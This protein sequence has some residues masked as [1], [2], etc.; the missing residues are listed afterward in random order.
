MG[1]S[2]LTRAEPIAGYTPIERVGAGGY[3]EV[4]KVDAP[5]GL[6]KAIK[7]VYG[8]MDDARAARE[9]KALNR[10]KQ[11]RHPF[12]LSLERIEV[13]DGQLLIVTELADMSLKDR[14]E[15]CRAEGLPGIPRDELL[16]YLR[17]AADAL[18]YMREKFSLQHLDVKPE[19]LLLVGGRVKVAD[20]GLVKDLHEVSMS[21]MGGMTPVYAPP[22]VF[23]DRA[24]EHSD[25]YSLAIVYQ[26]MLTGVLP[27]PGRTPAQLAAQHLHSRPLLGSLCEADRKIIARA[28]SKDPAQRFA[29]CKEMVEGLLKADP[30]GDDG[31]NES[32]ADVAVDDSNV[33]TATLASSATSVGQS[34]SLVEAEPRTGGAGS[35]R[36][37]P[38]TPTLAPGLPARRSSQPRRVT[39]SI[40]PAPVYDLPPI[41]IS[42]ADVGLRPT[43]C[44]GIGGTGRRVLLAMRRRLYQRFGPLEALPAWDMLLLDTDQQAVASAMQVDPTV[45]LSAGHQTLP[46]PLR[47]PQDYRAA[48]EKF[49]HWLSRRWLYNIPRSLQTQG[50]RPLGRLALVDHAQAVMQRLREAI[51]RVTDAEAI[52][53]SLETTQMEL[54]D[55]TPRIFVVASISGGAGSGMVLDVGYALRK[56][57]ADL[58]LADDGL[59]ALL[60]HATGH[61]AA[62]A[63]LATANAYACLTELYH[64]EQNDQAYP[65]DPALGLPS[66]R[67]EEKPFEDTYFVHFGDG[68]TRSAYQ[69]AVDRVAGYL[70]L[71]IATA[72]GACFDICRGLEHRSSQSAPR[73]PQVRSFGLSEIHC[74]VGRAAES[75]SQRACRRVVLRWLGKPGSAAERHDAAQQPSKIT[76]RVN[77]VAQACVR[78]VHLDVLP[79]VEHLHTMA[80]RSLGHDAATLARQVFEEAG[81]AARTGRDRQRTF[82]RAVA[83]VEQLLEGRAD[84]C[85]LN[86]P[87]A[88]SA[89][90]DADADDDEDRVRGVRTALADHV[91]LLGK[92]QGQMLRQCVLDFVDDPKGRLAAADDARNWFQL[93]LDGMRDELERLRREAQEERL[94]L[95]RELLRGDRG[96]RGGTS[97]WWLR[98]RGSAVPADDA[99]FGRYCQL[100]LS[101]VALD[102]V[103]DL[104]DMDQSHLNEV[105]R[106]IAQ[107]RRVLDRLADSFRRSQQRVVEREAET[108]AAEGELGRHLTAAVECAL[109]E[110]LSDFVTN[111]DQQFQQEFL[112][113]HGGL[114][115]LADDD[116]QLMGTLPE[117]LRLAAWATM[118]EAAQQ[119][120]VASLFLDQQTDREATCCLLRRC[121]DAAEP[122]L[123][124]TGG[125]RRWVAVLPRGEGD[126]RLYQLVRD[127]VDVAP[128]VVFDGDR[129]ITF[130]C[131]AQQLSLAKLAARLVES[132]PAAAQVASR[133]HVRNDVPWTEF[134][135][136]SYR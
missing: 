22:E 51:G 90:T 130:C 108:D 134:E 56:T 112:A 50:I 15:Q 94:Q 89:E 110:S 66:F 59:A 100:R 113:S 132:N 21:M 85:D 123:L 76:Q 29:S 115:A 57:L 74:D 128:T 114:S 103:G 82:D 116:P 49:L 95:Q 33:E 12:L 45:A 97:S 63:D 1:N 35:E 117:A 126:K 65:G 125:S 120:D 2:A 48:S 84:P 72:A 62:A 53:R 109:H 73:E 118:R 64:Y 61:D 96:A 88:G 9:L 101:E 106:Q 16:V 79:L 69:T 44:I 98:W 111:I 87:P 104:I 81:N 10:I 30:L 124:T 46:L 67:P 107:I 39:P 54:R 122:P 80:E 68:L 20:F 17:D 40:E 6:V 31:G 26:E 42:A 34:G 36:S 135:L 133:I 129:D 92:E 37:K 3:G 119:I 24:S 43:L 19:N 99:Q 60:V 136:P 102:A 52:E 78:T 83:R 28:L 41:E 11:V 4:W 27:F 71:D 47:R 32:S 8:H 55:R 77:E 38:S 91:Q 127:T 58:E 23:D 105:E 70:Y 5:G 14:F 121:H 7:F 75:E 131:E 18:D 86:E 13:V 93:H 25:Q